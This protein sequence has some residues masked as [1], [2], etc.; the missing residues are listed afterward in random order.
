[1]LRLFIG[2]DERQEVSYTVAARSALEHTSA[3]LQ[4]TP[5][6]LSALK[7]IGFTRMGLTPFTFSR[8]LVPYLCD[9]AGPPAIFVDADVMWRDDPYKL[10]SSLDIGPTSKTAM[11][12]RK[13][14]Q[15]E[16]TAVMVFSPTH[17][18]LR[19]LTPQFVQN[20]NPFDIDSWIGSQDYVADLPSKWH[21]LVLY[22]QPSPDAKLVHF[23]AGVPSF[24][25]LDGCEHTD[26][27]KRHVAAATGLHVSWQTLLGKTQHASV[28]DRWRKEKG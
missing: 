8:F 16:R 21:H 2:Y 13:E 7:V 28:V 4:I 17:H 19:V 1:M 24:R 3:P 25:E 5:L 9:F 22:D 18:A 27:Y 11:L 12:V 10:I 20:G 26:E 23:T 6:K 15:F 14:P